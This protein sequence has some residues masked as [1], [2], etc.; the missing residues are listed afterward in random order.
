MKW[1]IAFATFFWSNTLLA[2]VYPDYK[3]PVPDKIV[4][5]YACQTHEIKR[6]YQDGAATAPKGSQFTSIISD[7]AGNLYMTGQSAFDI[8]PNNAQLTTP[9]TF[10]SNLTNPQTRMRAQN[11]YHFIC[12]YFPDGQLNWVTFF[13][14]K[15]E[16]IVWNEAE[17]KLYALIKP[18]NYEIEVNGSIIQLDT[19]IKYIKSVVLTLDNS[20]GGV[21][22]VYHHN[23]IQDILVAG[24]KTILIYSNGDSYAYYFGVMYG[25]FKNNQVVKWQNTLN[26]TNFLPT[27]LYYNT[28]DNSFW[29]LNSNSLKYRRLFLHPSADSIITENIDR[30]IYYENLPPYG[31]LSKPKSFQFTPDGSVIS[32]MNLHPQNSL[33]HANRGLVKWDTS[34]NLLW[35]MNVDVDKAIVTND[36]NLWLTFEYVDY[37][38]RVTVHPGNYEYYINTYG[39]MVEPKNYLW[40]IN[41]A[42]GELMEAYRNGYGNNLYP[43]EHLLHI[44]KDN[45][46]I[47]TPQ[48]GA[49]AYYP[50]ASGNFKPYYTTCSNNNMTSQFMWVRFDLNNIKSYKWDEQL[51][52][53]VFSQTEQPTNLFTVYPNPSAN[54]FSVLTGQSEAFELYDLT[55]KMLDKFFVTEKEVYTY[56]HSLP[57]GVYV[58]R[59]SPSGVMKKIIVH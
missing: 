49:V 9:I 56:R 59:G 30:N 21:S 43:S 28:Y 46:L 58:L 38:R 29:Y 16:K 50:D 1:H 34:G 33:F 27:E 14:Q 37:Y 15:P 26:G 55:G 10:C 5:N 36:G 4:L 3:V 52:E 48:M 35:K 19:A 13:R 18:N 11:H 42:T 8:D 51:E 23:S 53:T 31:V 57:Q 20:N 2:Q 41:G 6:L 47:A 17:Q 32:E 39:N 44:T 54:E 24:N 12:K 7:D 22:S 25:F 40:K 45:K